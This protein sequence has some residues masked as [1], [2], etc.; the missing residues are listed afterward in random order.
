[1]L[2]YKRLASDVDVALGWPRSVRKQR[3][4]WL[5]AQIKAENEAIKKQSQQS[6]HG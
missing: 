5:E 2:A 6:S 1:M 4:A 3:I